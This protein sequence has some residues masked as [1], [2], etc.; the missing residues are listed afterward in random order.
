MRE[1]DRGKDLAAALGRNGNRRLNLKHLAR[2]AGT[3]P[4]FAA[5]YMARTAFEK[6]GHK[7]DRL[8]REAIAALQAEGVALTAEA[9]AVRAAI[10]IAAARMR[11]D[12]MGKG[13]NTDALIVEAFRHLVVEMGVLL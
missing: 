12:R 2:D 5:E 1:R 13:Q 8:F 4:K 7:R 3:T 11:L 6:T 10:P 9:I